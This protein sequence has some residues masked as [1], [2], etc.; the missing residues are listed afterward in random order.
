VNARGVLV[1]KAKKDWSEKKSKYE[2]YY[3]H[4]EL[5]RN[6]PSHRMLAI[7]RGTDEG[8]LS[9]KIDVE[10]D[11]IISFMESRIIKREDFMFLRN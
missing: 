8:V 7:R 1:S 2:N 5:I 4:T 6:A 10:E 3:M 9:W 11:E